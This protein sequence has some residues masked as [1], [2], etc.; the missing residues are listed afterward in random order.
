MSPILAFHVSDYLGRAVFGEM[1]RYII[2]PIAV[3]IS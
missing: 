3:I 2:F 1:A